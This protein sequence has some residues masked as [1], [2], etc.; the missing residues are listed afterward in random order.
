MS[1]A[2]TEG[3]RWLGVYVIAYQNDEPAEIYFAGYSYD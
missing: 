1:V 3:G 2:R